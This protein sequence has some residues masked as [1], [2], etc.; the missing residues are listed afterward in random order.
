[1]KSRIVAAIFTLTLLAGTAN[2]ERLAMLP[3]SGT[4]IHEGYLAAAQDLLRGH[5]LATGRYYVVALPGQAGTV[6]TNGMDAAAL[7]RDNGADLALVLHVTRLGSSA[8][9]RMTVYDSSGRVVHADQLGAA[10][11]DDFD[12]VLKRM[13]VGLAT[14]RAAKETADIETVT[15]KE[16]DPLRKME[17]T[18]VFGIK[19]GGVTPLVE[20][21]N[22]VPGGAV[23][24]LYDMRSFLAEIDIGFHAGN[25][26][27]DFG[28]GI[29]AYYPLSRQN[30]TPF[31]GGGLRYQ[32]SDYGNDYDGA[33]LA[34]FGG[35][36]VLIGRLNTVQLRADV[37]YFFTTYKEDRFD[38]QSRLAHG[39]IFDIGIGF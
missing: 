13:A 8:K 30:T 21:T 37:N 18:H 4:N 2:A 27:G 16:A 32:T 11:P 31:I 39:L 38:D 28:V 12:P 33:G 9:I 10:N 15:E 26:G 23:F 36:G 24:W 17:A 3:P 19:L 20:G 6:E 5:L 14:G 35:G 25:G 29:G 1:M 7:A 22:M 34:V